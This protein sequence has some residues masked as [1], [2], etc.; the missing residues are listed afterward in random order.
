M[1]SATARRL[2]KYTIHFQHGPTKPA[3]KRTC[4]Y[5][6]YL[7]IYFL[8]KVMIIR[9]ALL[10]AT[11]DIH[12]SFSVC[13]F[14]P[15]P[16]GSF[17]M[18]ILPCSNR[19]VD[20]LRKQGAWKKKSIKDMHIKSRTGFLPNAITLYILLLL[21]HTQKRGGGGGT[22]SRLYIVDRTQPHEFHG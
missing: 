7:F 22:R 18:D 15:D 4:W 3:I 13:T 8:K 21:F 2:S 5:A 12:N 17:S 1:E 6:F 10:R 16:R 20:M 19:P 11:R 9:A 14:W